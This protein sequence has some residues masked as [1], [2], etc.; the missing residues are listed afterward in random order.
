MLHMHSSIACNKLYGINLKER[1]K[2]ERNAQQYYNAY[3]HSVAQIPKTMG[4]IIMQ[5]CTQLLVLEKHW[6]TMLN[7][8][9]EWY[10]TDI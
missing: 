3:T 6:K 2:K 10:F 9:T 8:R 5:I 1:K 4:N 7:T